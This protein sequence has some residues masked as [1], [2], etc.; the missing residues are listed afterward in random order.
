MKNPRADVL[1]LMY[2]DCT[3][4]SILVVMLYYSFAGCYHWGKLAK[5]YMDLS[6]LFL[7]N[8]CESTTISKF[9]KKLIKS[10]IKH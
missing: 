7:A 10:K 3:S 6:V 8:I 1:C 2:L 9:K 4:A 5:G